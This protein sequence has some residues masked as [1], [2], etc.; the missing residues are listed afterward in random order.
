MCVCVVDCHCCFLFARVVACLCV[1]VVVFVCLLG[2]VFV[3]RRFVVLC[4][5]LFGWSVVCLPVRL[6]L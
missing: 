5:S 6:F 2:G 3:R 4:V 1:C